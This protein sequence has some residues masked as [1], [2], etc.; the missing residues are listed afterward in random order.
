MTT[1]REKTSLLIAETFHIPLDYAN[2]LATAALNGID[3]HGGDPGDWETIVETVNV[4]VKSW[5]EHGD[6]KTADDIPA[7]GRA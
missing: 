4:V 6:L 3:S 7:S 1:M 5:I 2:R